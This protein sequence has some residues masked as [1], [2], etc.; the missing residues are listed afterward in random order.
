MPRSRFASL[1]L[2]VAAMITG[3]CGLALEPRFFKEAGQ[4]ADAAQSIDG[5]SSADASASDGAVV[6]L[7]R[8]VPVE[9]A[10][11]I[12]ADS[13]TTGDA[14]AVSD[15]IIEPM[16]DATLLDAIALD[17]V[18][19]ADSGAAT[20]G[21]AATDSGVRSDT[22]VLVDSGTRVDGGIATDGGGGGA[23]DGGDSGAACGMGSFFCG[24]MCVP[25]DELN[26]GACGRSCSFGLVCIRG[27]CASCSA[28]ET[29]CSDRNGNR[30]CAPMC[31]ALLMCMA[32][33]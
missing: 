9:D 30:C 3:G 28:G 13:A 12:G 22:G 2:F 8:V 19:R 20:D 6:V 24:G 31:S 11:V 15:V 26:C 14:V 10:I 7:D 5:G 32:V 21:G 23:R 16:L 4:I 1:S 25:S 17:A 33:D 29:A 27:M 18:V